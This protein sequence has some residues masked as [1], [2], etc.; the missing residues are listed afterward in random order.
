M[1]QDLRSQAEGIAV[2]KARGA[3]VE[4]AG[5]FCAARCGGNRVRTAGRPAAHPAHT[6]KDA[7]MGRQR[8]R[9]RGGKDE[10]MRE[11]SWRVFGKQRQTRQAGAVPCAEAKEWGSLSRG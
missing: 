11:R 2:G 7:E 10:V 1:R 9:A 8:A 5:A 4:D 6:I 3:V